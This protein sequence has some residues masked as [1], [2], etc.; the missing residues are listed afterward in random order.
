MK[1]KRIICIDGD[2]SIQINIQELQTAKFNNL[3]IKIFIFNNDGYGIIKQFQDLYL[4][5]RH[6]AT[7]NKK[8]VSNPDFKKIA[9]AYGIKYSNI[10]TNKEIE[11]KLTKVLKNKDLEIIEIFVEKEQKI[12]PKLEYGRP[13]EDLSPLLDR[14]LF[15]EIM[16]SNQ[17]K[18]KNSLE[19]N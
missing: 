3:P 10:K 18:S 11:T 6:E 19:I 13:I 7:I 5:K 8:G 17:I 12:I 4:G 15:S 2:G 16:G 14:K 1:K 9:Y